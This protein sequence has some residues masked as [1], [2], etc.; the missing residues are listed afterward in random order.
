MNHNT[1]AV[2]HRIARL[3]R[4]WA[5][6]YATGM[7]VLRQ[8]DTLHPVGFYLLYPTASESEAAFFQPPSKALHLS[9]LR[10]VDPFQMAQPGD[11]ECVAI[12]I[13]SWMI[14]EEYRADYQRSFLQDSQQTVRRMMQDFPNLCDLHTLLIH[15]RYEKLAALLGFQTIT[16]DKSQTVYWAYQAIDRFLALDLEQISDL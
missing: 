5:N 6:Q 15:P 8:P 9:T 16:K 10:E 13:R 12:F 1:E 3:L 7:R 11:P 2:P 4:R 14:E